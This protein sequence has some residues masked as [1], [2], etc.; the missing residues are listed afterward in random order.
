MIDKYNEENNN[1]IKEYVL[2]YMNNSDISINE[3][4]LKVHSIFG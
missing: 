1:K 3:C 4:A 2:E